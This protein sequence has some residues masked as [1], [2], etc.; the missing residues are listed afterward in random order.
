MAW[1]NLDF[2]KNDERIFS[3]S[4]EDIIYPLCLTVRANELIDKE[5]G[6][7]GKVGK[8]LQQ[9]AEK[10]EITTVMK[11]TNKLLLALISGGLARCQTKAKMR[12]EKIDLP[13]MPEANDLDSLFT[14]EDMPNVQSAIFAALGGGAKR[15]VETAPDNAPK[16][17]EEATSSG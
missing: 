15:N 17:A 8:I 2:L 7:V 13:N 5:F 3:I 10:E 14:Y 4:I 1:E 11:M 16:N 6:S 12:G 9:H